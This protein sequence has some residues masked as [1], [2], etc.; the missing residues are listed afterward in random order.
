MSA[1]FVVLIT[2]VLSLGQLVSQFI[3]LPF[4]LSPFNAHKKILSSNKETCLNFTKICYIKI[5][6]TPKNSVNKLSNF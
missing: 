6:D 5:P 1:G 2:L 3:F 4:L